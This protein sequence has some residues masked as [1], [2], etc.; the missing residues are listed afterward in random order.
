MKKETLLRKATAYHRRFSDELGNEWE[1]LTDFKGSHEMLSARHTPCG[2]IRTSEARRF[3]TQGCPVCA[4]AEAKKNKAKRKAQEYVRQ[5]EEEYGVTAKSQYCGMREPMLWKCDSC[6]ATLEKTVENILWRKGEWG[7]GLI[8]DCKIDYGN[9]YLSAGTLRIIKY[10]RRK[11]I[12]YRREVWW[13]TCRVIHPLP[14]DFVVY[15]IDGN[16]I[17]A[18]EHNGQQHYMPVEHLGGE[19][20]FIRQQNADRVKANWC[21]ENG[22]PLLSVRFDA[23]IEVELDLFF[24]NL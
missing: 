24:N 4:Q 16:P 14:F 21:K 13:D 2:T 18:I 15:D 11:G 23:D 5:I 6:G 1:R 20:R 10:L 8:C 12:P 22:M 3:F 9:S 19:D 17:C 7:G